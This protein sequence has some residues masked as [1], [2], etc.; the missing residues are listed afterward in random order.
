M[1]YVPKYIYKSVKYSRDIIYAYIELEPYILETMSQS[2]LLVW[3]QKQ[4]PKHWKI[5]KS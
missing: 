3:R 1:I 4:S 2:T 5:N